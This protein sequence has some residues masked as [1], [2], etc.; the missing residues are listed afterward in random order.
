MQR[1][2]SLTYIA[3]TSLFGFHCNDKSP[4]PSLQRE[5]SLTFILTT[6]LLDLHCHDKTSWPSLQRQFSLT[7]IEMTNILDSLQRQ[8]SLTYMATTRLLDL[9]F[10]ANSHWRTLQWYFS[11]TYVGTTSLLDLHLN[12]KSYWPT[13]LRKVLTNPLHLNH[14]YSFSAYSA[15]NVKFSILVDILQPY[16]VICSTVL[17]NA[18]VFRRRCLLYRNGDSSLFKYINCV[19]PWS[20]NVGTLFIYIQRVTQNLKTHCKRN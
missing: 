5:V 13:S 15:K 4:W 18:W 1:Q 16:N 8:V 19:V 17:N 3:T 14:H 12:D 11:L 6:S 2:V 7:F 20:E 10:S 9:H